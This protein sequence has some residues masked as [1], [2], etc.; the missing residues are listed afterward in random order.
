MSENVNLKGQ[1]TSCN[2]VSI[3]V[4][5]ADTL[6]AKSNV[7][8][9]EN[10]L[11]KTA[12]P[13]GVSPSTTSGTHEGTQL[14]HLWF[15]S[16]DFH[17]AAKIVGMTVIK[18]TLRGEV[19]PIPTK[20][21]H[22]QPLRND[23]HPSSALRHNYH[24]ACNP[25]TR[26]TEFISRFSHCFKPLYFTQMTTGHYLLTQILTSTYKPYSPKVKIKQS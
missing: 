8:I 12:A 17:D 16:Q 23:C 18:Q 14:D 1:E 25:V 9:P 24:P 19:Q 3:S 4:I 15:T 11:W 20:A 10:V 13:S 26:D 7:T 22:S 2:C 21:T 6:T 5:S